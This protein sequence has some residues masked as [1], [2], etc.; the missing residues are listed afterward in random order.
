MFLF[1]APETWKKR[2]QKLLIIGP[3]LFFSTGL[4]AQTAQKQKSFHT[5]KSP[6]MQD[7]IF[8]LGLLCISWERERCCQKPHGH[9]QNLNGYALPTRCVALCNMHDFANLER[10]KRKLFY[11]HIL[12]QDDSNIIFQKG[13]F[14]Y[15]NHQVR[16]SKYYNYLFKSKKA[17]YS[18][19]T[20]SCWIL[21]ETVWN[22]LFL[23]SIN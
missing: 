20:A 23:G 11:P 17:A 2:P 5:T 3:D 12:P 22:N 14:F 15:E 18:L 9:S 13:T 10:K 21:K 8:R 7:W 19:K 6:L 16:H 4:A 1:F